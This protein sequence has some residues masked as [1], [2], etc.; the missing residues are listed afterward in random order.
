MKW[1]NQI[2]LVGGEST[3]R[4]GF[5]VFL[6]DGVDAVDCDWKAS[7]ESLAPSSMSSSKS[8]ASLSATGRKSSK[9]SFSCSLL[10]VIN[11]FRT[12]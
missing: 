1:Q 3:F 4:I 11:D 5:G 8:S 12:S 2:K 6:L 10:S 7:K 9:S